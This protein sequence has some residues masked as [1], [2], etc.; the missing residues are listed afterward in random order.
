MKFFTTTQGQVELPPGKKVVPA[1]EFSKLCEAADLLKQAKTDAKDLLDD[2]NNECVELKKE[3][4]RNGLQEGLEKFAEQLLVFDQ[5]V[6]EIAISMQ[7]EILG[8][9]L[10]AA[11]KIVGEELKTHPETIVNI[12]QQAIRPVLQH[13]QI[14]IWVNRSDL[15]LLDEKKE[16]IKNA[17]ERIVSFGFEERADIE[18][19]SCVVETEA[20]I[21]NATLDN[22]WRAIQN[23]F[24]SFD[25]GNA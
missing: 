2:V 13:H 16:E 21:I 12:V 22:Q 3:A 1:E 10:S 5:K 24:E 6:K 14:K 7:D 9:A 23:A 18:P 19:G 25:K 20:G 11:K 15:P 4:R 8:I 17:F